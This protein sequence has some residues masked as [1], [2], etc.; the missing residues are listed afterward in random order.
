MVFV[1][2]VSCSRLL[3]PAFKSSVLFMRLLL[4]IGGEG[5]KGSKCQGSPTEDLNGSRFAHFFLAKN[6]RFS[7][8]TDEIS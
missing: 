2:F 1:C 6:K 3:F 7:G 5:P 8:N 4:L